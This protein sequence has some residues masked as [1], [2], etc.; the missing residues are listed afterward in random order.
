[1]SYL[2]AGVFAE[3]PTDYAFLLPLLDH[4]LP[5]LAHTAL[6][7][8]PVIGDSVGIDA[9]GRP[10]ARRADR[11]AAAI[12]AFFGQCTLFVI[13]SDGEG[14]P[15]RALRERIEPGIAVARASR[16]DLAIAAC[17][18]VR[19]IEAWLL[20]D[21]RPFENLLRSSAPPLLPPDPEAVLDPK[22]ELGHL[23]GA[24]GGPK[25]RTDVYAF[26]GANAGM[27]GLRRLPAFRRFEEQLVSAIQAAA[28]EH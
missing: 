7:R 18:P 20:A 21:N 14:D 19:E 25:L 22:L 8:V 6:S 28:R 24:G 27:T 4:M 1:M 16:P 17:V 13:H 23:L 11:I 2:C 5:D 12:N 26:F 15:E 3:G 10:P 9:P